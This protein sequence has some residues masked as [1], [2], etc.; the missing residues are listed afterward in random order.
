MFGFLFINIIVIMKTSK[1]PTKFT[2]LESYNNDWNN[3]H[4][5][6]YINIFKNS[7]KDRALQQCL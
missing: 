1:F 2:K 6:I 3:K 4:I 5:K 7:H